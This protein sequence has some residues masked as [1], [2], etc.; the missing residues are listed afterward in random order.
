MLPDA[1]DRCNKKCTTETSKWPCKEECQQK[2]LSNRLV[3]LNLVLMVRVLTVNKFLM[4]SLN[5]PM[6]SLTML[7]P[8]LP[9]ANQLTVRDRLSPKLHTGIE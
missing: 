9:M 2:S 1:E 3:Q 4:D 5:L 7:H 8:K 6:V